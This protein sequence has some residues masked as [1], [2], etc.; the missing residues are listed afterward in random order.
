[1]CSS[2]LLHFR[3]HSIL[4]NMIFL[5]KL[6]RST[7]FTVIVPLNII[8]LHLCNFRQ[9]VFCLNSVFYCS[10]NL[11][12]NEI[13]ISYN[14]VNLL[15]CSD[16]S[17]LYFSLSFLSGITFRMLHF[18]LYHK[19]HPKGFP[20]DLCI[21]LHLKCLFYTVIMQKFS[22]CCKFSDLVRTGKHISVCLFSL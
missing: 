17:L 16:C 6:I 19:Q 21:Y 5:F 2:D 14:T 11:I 9:F 22:I 13:F 4:H 7:W 1:M 10:A 15:P 18:S 3:R 20:T 8:R 12:N